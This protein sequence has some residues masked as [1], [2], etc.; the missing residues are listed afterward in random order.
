LRGLL[1]GLK[2]K[3]EPGY[4]TLGLKRTECEAA[5]QDK[6]ECWDLGKFCIPQKVVNFLSS[7]GLRC[8][9][10]AFCCKKL[11]SQCF[12][13]PEFDGFQSYLVCIS[14]ATLYSEE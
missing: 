11:V 1:I 5:T 7:E 3:K 4:I 12:R 6:F 14:A 9:Q 13:R 8:S 2:A 10:E